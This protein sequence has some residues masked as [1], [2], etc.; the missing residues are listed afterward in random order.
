MSDLLTCIVDLR[1]EA[2][3]TKAQR[4]RKAAMAL[5]SPTWTMNPLGFVPLAGVHIAPGWLEYNGQAPAE[6][7]YAAIKRL[8]ADHPFPDGKPFVLWA[9]G[10]NVLYGLNLASPGCAEAFAQI[11]IDWAYWAKIIGF[12]YF[13]T[14]AWLLEVREGGVLP[15]WASSAYY[16]DFDA[17]LRMVCAT[18]RELRPDLLI[19]G[20]QY[21]ETRATSALDG[22]FLE[23]RYTRAFQFNAIADYFEAIKAKR[24]ADRAF[25]ILEQRDMASYSPEQSTA[26]AEFCKL[27]GYYLSRGKDATAIGNG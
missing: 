26:I 5:V 6:P 14:T 20:Y 15:K 21:H 10:G 2:G 22:P 25:G 16:E 19:T 27:H 7:I 4:Q 11:V 23:D 13:T 9:G 17:G 18:A 3:W 1:G 24:N 12:D 8:S